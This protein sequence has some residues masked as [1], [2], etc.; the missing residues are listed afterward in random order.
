MTS[1]W[2]RAPAVLLLVAIAW[3]WLAGTSRSEAG[4]AAASRVRSSG[5]PGE[6]PYDS[7]RGDSVGEAVLYL[8]WGAPWG[9]PG[10]RRNIM[11]SCDDTARVDTLYLSLE[12]GRDLPRLVAMFGRI[13]FHPVA[14]DSL[15]AF[16]GFGQGGANRGGLLVQMDADGTF[17]CGQPWLYPGM[18]GTMYE[19]AGGTGELLVIYAVEPEDGAPIAGRTRYCFARLLL[20]HQHCRLEGAKQPVCVEWREAG[21]SGGGADLLVRRGAERFVSVNSP[22]CAVC[23]PYRHRLD[24]SPWRPPARADSA[25]R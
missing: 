17:P 3:P 12:T 20:R 16:W 2:R 5:V 13:A 11:V 14:G 9:M 24:V 7:T 1:G 18:G 10:A 22:D 8:S 25:R 23:G 19:V 15:G 6:A 4:L 21:Y